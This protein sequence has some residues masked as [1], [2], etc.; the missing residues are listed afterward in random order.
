MDAVIRWMRAGMR[1]VSYSTE[2]I[3]LQEAATTAVWRL[4]LASG[5]TLPREPENAN[6]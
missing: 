2:A 1:F 6:R 4:R 5:E 3:L